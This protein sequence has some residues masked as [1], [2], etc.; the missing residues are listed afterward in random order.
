V[1]FKIELFWLF[2]EVI[3]RPEQSGTVFAPSTVTNL[4]KAP[5][6]P[7]RFLGKLVSSNHGEAVCEDEA[8][9]QNCEMTS[10]IVQTY[11]SDCS[12]AVDGD[13]ATVTLSKFQMVFTCQE[14]GD[15]LS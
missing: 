1:R 7:F 8:Y 3:W 13:D 12:K 4:S 5:S 9:S 6:P 11:G 2:V 15:W 10:E 14:R